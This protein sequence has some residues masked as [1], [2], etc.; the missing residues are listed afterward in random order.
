MYE[1]TILCLPIPTITG[2]MAGYEIKVLS[3]STANCQFDIENNARDNFP[4]DKK[5][6]YIF[7]SLL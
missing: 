1:R 2:R 6:S 7:S 4:L 5:R 3:Y